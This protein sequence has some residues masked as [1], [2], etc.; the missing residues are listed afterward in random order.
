MYSSCHVCLLF[1]QGLVR[2]FVTV[3][4]RLPHLLPLPLGGGEG[5]A[6]HEEGENGE[7]QEEE[8]KGMESKADKKV[9]AGGEARRVCAEDE[10]AVSMGDRV[11][12]GREGG[13][14]GDD[15]V[16]CDPT[17]ADIKAMKMHA[18]EDVSVYSHSGLSS[19]A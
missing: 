14:C 17:K 7:E 19:S 6:A 12:R 2:E 15:F 8:E 9:G 10:E 1:P 18:I 5:T 3:H 11:G 16:P 13:V 4:H